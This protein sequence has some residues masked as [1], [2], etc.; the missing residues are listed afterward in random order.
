MIANSVSDALSPDL[1]IGGTG[2]AVDRL[3][4]D[5]KLYLALNG[6]VHDAAIAAW[7]LKG[8]YDSARPITLI[9]YMGGK[10]Q[11]SDPSQPA[12]HP[13]GLPLEPGLV[14]VITSASTAPGQRHEALK[15]HEG[16]IAVRAWLA[17]PKN[18]KADTAGVGWRLATEWVPYQMKTFV[19]PAFP[20][21]VSGHSTFS[22]A[23][24]EVMTAVTG[25]AFFPG[26]QS[27]FTAKAGSLKFES[28]PAADVPL[29]WA[30]YFD[31]ADQAGRSRLWGG[32]HIAADDLT[33]REI[34]SEVGIDAVERRPALLRWDGRVVTRRGRRVAV[35]AGTVGVLAVV[36]IAGVVVLGRVP[37]PSH[38][39]GAPRFVEE[40][41]TAGLVHTYDGGPTFATGG[42]VAVLD[43]DEDGRPDLYL[44]GG[45]NAAQLFRNGSAIGGGLMFTPAGDTVTDVTGVTGAY[46]L[47]VDADGHTDLAVLRVG[48]TLLLRGLGGCRFERANEAWGLGLPILR[49]DDR[50]LGDLGGGSDPAHA[51]P[52]QLPRA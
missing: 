26:G 22:R 36:A 48:E 24:A 44:A 8:H 33:G 20:G 6:A 14:E 16:E 3:E 1:R 5:T 46:P 15:G 42:G 13:E 41:A 28:G 19:T 32:I 23:A 12:Y 49:V 27:G 38:A 25:S 17:Y 10:G 18:P 45:A 30:T 11:S 37:T 40:T 29:Q 51:C 39:L 31:A 52:R 34:G 21:F 50:I 7:G 35:A 43:C 2:S 47:D 4:W 9:R